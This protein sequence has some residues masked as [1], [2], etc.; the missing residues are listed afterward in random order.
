MDSGNRLQKLWL[1]FRPTLL[2]DLLQLLKTLVK[3]TLTALSALL[4]PI[5]DAPFKN[6]KDS[7]ALAG[8]TTVEAFKGVLGY[9]T[10]IEVESKKESETPT[11]P[12]KGWGEIALENKGRIAL[13][14]LGAAALCTAVYFRKDILSAFS[15]VDNP[16]VCFP[17]EKPQFDSESPQV[18]AVNSTYFSNVVSKVEKS[19]SPQ[20]FEAN[21]TDFLKAPLV[22]EAN[23]VDNST[24]CFANE[25]P[26]SPQVLEANPNNFSNVVS[27]NQIVNEKLSNEVLEIENNF[28]EDV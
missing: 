18:C 24:I 12:P 16:N 28:T 26:A 4:Y 5:T 17:Y 1:E 10:Q 25:K 11:T 23:L 13:F 8:R 15:K 6:L 19:A 7:T 3:A 21:P 22:R 2:W 27:L 9:S 20:V 14:V